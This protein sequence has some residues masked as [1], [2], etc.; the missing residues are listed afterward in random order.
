MSNFRKLD[1]DIFIGPQPTAQDLQEAKQQGIK[2]VI[3]LRM[4][5]ETTGSNELLTQN[6][7]LGYANIPVN[8]AALST[9]QVGQLDAVMK[10][11]EGPFLLHCATG[12]R[13]ALLLSLNQA[14]RHRWTAE[15]TFDAAKKMGYD[16][17][18]SPE[19]SA[20]VKQTRT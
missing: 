4:P 20:F 13:A 3:D 12:A 5:A 2:T 15:Q 8:K 6:A 17:Q 9:D 14:N 19:F 18:T 16:L 10:N 11:N 1:D 7:G